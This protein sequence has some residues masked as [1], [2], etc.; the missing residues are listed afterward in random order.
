MRLHKYLL[1]VFAV[2][3][4]LAFFSCDDDTSINVIEGVQEDEFG[5]QPE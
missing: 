3:A 1:L 4:S 5:V 2:F